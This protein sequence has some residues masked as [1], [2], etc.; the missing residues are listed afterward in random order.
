[1]YFIS[2]ILSIYLTDY[3]LYSESDATVIYHIFVMLAYLFPLAGAVIADS[4]LGK[5]RTILYLSF[6]YVFGNV[7]LS[8]SA[9]TPLG[10]PSREFALLGLVL[11]AIGTGG[12]KPCVVPFGGD[13]FVLPQQEKLLAS[14]FSIFYLSVNLGSF[15][16]SAITPVLREDVHCFEEESCYPLAFGTSAILMLSATGK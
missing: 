4:L 9:I 8:L 1:M 15:I 14:Y 7:I 11:I 5:F 2:A 13:Q 6:V 10:L 16:S 12:I 3:L